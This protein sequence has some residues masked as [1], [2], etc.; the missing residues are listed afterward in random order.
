MVEILQNQNSATRFRVM[1]EI[2]ANQPNIQQKYIA[3][4]L[5]ITPQAV[6][7][8]MKQLLSDGL[9]LSEGRSRSRLSLEGI[10]WLIRQTRAAEEYLGLVEQMISNIRVSATIADQKLR[11]GQKVGVIMKEGILFAT[12]DKGVK[13]QGIVESDA[14]PGDDVGVSSIQ[15]IIK[16]E[17]GEVTI[18]EVP[19]VQRGGSSMADL[20]RLRQEA[21]GRKPLIAIGIEAITALKRIDIKPDYIYA[22]KEVAVDAAR[23]GL[24]P[25]VVCI[26]EE[27]L[28]LVTRLKGAGIKHR[29]INLTK[30]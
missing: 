30:P 19:T 25:L 9:L 28:L 10:D 17:T 8:Y 3:G 24:S 26:D 1:V 15:G 16:L 29:L 21:A 23:L 4:R 14:A 5:G 7:D 13:A 20:G 6:S 11:K 12:T 18:A 2:A 27:T 22:A